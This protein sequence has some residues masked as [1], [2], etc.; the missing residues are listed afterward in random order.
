MKNLINTLSLTLFFLYQSLVYGQ[1]YPIAD[2]QF[3]ECIAQSFADLLDDNGALILSKA[4]IVDSLDCSDFAISNAD[5]LQYFTNLKVLDLHNND[6]TRLDELVAL[7]V[8]EELYIQENELVELP[9]LSSLTSLKKIKANSNFITTTPPLPSQLQYLDLS[10]NN[11]TSLG[12]LSN[13]H[14][15]EYL[16][17]FRN[18]KLKEIPSLDGL[19]KLKELSC[20]LCGLS[21][22]PEMTNLASLE[23]INTGY[24]NLTTL[25]ELTS[26]K[27]LKLIYANNNTLTSFPNMSTLPLLERVRLY[28]NYLSFEDFVPLLVNE[29]YED[30]YKIT[31][32]WLFKNPLK[33]N[34]FEFD[35]VNFKTGISRNTVGTNYS[36]FFNGK[37]LSN[38]TND[39]ITTD[40]IKVENSGLY[41]YEV[42]H[43]LFPNLIL[44]SDTQ[45]VSV[46]SCLYTSGFQVDIVGATCQ[47]A[48]SL[49]IIALNQP[50]QN[51]TYK[52]QSKATDRV[53]TSGNGVFNN[54]SN[55]S[56]KLY[57]QA[58]P[59]CVKLINNNLAIPIE[60]CKDAYFTP[61]NDGVDDY[62][63]FEQ[64]GDAKIYNKW[65]QLIQTLHLPVEWNGVL[66]DG[67]TI[68]PGYYTIDINDGEEILKLSV[69]Y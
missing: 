55:P 24:N 19:L 45:Q 9:D 69:I 36:W 11:L 17:V 46:T 37:L 23:F 39:L 15:L 8:I 52:L 54:L 25:P 42:T 28:N 65:G 35:S 63:Y 64:I 3:K 50:Q 48:G 61:N 40:S 6:F 1:T 10:Q 14:E 62:F 27:K 43:P 60:K 26:N 29:N 7:S 32:Q 4:A 57:A 34:Y 18:T 22:L 44:H 13:L 41:H 33:N 38:S 56:Y 21:Q 47:K 68:M 66:S 30:I 2:T 53:L 16:L 58:G 12:D 67:K 31:P 20:Y 51:L 49:K 59:R 5:G